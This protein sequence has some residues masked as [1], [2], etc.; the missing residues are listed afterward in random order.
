MLR[1]GANKARSARTRSHFAIV[2]GAIAGVNFSAE[3]TST[4]ISAS[5]RD[6]LI[7]MRGV[8]LAC[9][10]AACGNDAGLLLD[11]HPGDPAVTRVEVLLPDSQPGKYMGVPSGVLPAAQGPR[12]VGPVYAVVDRT[13]GTIDG[14]GALRVLLTPGEVTEV[15]AILVLGYDAN[16]TPI[17]YAVVSNSPD[18]TDP[19][20]SGDTIKLPHAT[21]AHLVVDLEPIMTVPLAGAMTATGSPRL[22]RWDGT[23]FDDASARC[24][25]VLSENGS[26]HAG[27]FFG[28]ADD[29]DCDH[30]Q[31]E[32]DQDWYMRVRGTSACATTMPP[33]DDM[34]TMN[35][36][37]IGKS[38]GCVDGTG[39]SNVCGAQSPALCVPAAI[40]DQCED[41]DPSC[42]AQRMTDPA[43]S[44][45]ECTIDVRTDTGTGD[46]LMCDTPATTVVRPDLFG[47]GYSCSG[48]I[49]FADPMSPTSSAS[50]DLQLAGAPG[51]TLT[52]TCHGDM[53]TFEL[54]VTAPMIGVPVDPALPE[55][56]SVVVIGVHS[57]GNPTQMRMLSVPIHV[58]YRDVTSQT[59]CAIP[60][61][62]CDLALDA[63]T[64]ADDPLW[65]CAG[66]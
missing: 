7:A 38:P 25:G 3:V 8:V 4:S 10:L 58:S 49:G 47:P 41:L 36:C 19:N 39:S 40:C 28:P 27:I 30:A 42:V 20:A 11:V 29:L 51:D 24:F 6:I 18:P 57:V 53:T 63:S 48:F 62:Q 17:R 16:D 60:A 61:M 66:S 54:A 44:H 46:K 64:Q 45:I 65:H 56:Q 33:A 37:R 43:T 23:A 55:T 14:D 52:F 34:D 5:R 2:E 21:S 22:V 35:A 50:A 59:A 1:R 32:C 12:I 31:P 9:V 13:G 15:P 26:M